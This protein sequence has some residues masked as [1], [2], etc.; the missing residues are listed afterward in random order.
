LV[1]ANPSPLLFL[2]A[3]LRKEVREKNSCNKH[4]TAQSL[5]SLVQ[6]SRKYSEIPAFFAGFERLNRRISLQLRLAGGGKGI[7]TLGTAFGTMKTGDYQSLTVIPSLKRRLQI[8]AGTS[9]AILRSTLGKV[10]PSLWAHL[11]GGFRVRLTCN[12]SESRKLLSGGRKPKP[13]IHCSRITEGFRN[14]SSANTPSKP[15]TSTHELSSLSVLWVLRNPKEP[16]SIT[17]P[18]YFPQPAPDGKR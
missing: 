5:V 16:T 10:K 13:G 9:D 4:D 6:F 18:T 3:G 7:R 17:R 2:E 8:M 11:G 15:W 1:I 14:S 12:S